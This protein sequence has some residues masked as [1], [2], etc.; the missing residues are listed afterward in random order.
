MNYTSL[1]AQVVDTLGS[2]VTTAQVDAQLAFVE[3]RF[4]RIIDSPEREKEAYLTPTADIQLPADCWRL[5]DIWVMGTASSDVPTSLVQVSAAQARALYAYETNGIEAY[6]LTGRTIDF[7]PDP[8]TSNT[9]QVR[10]RYQQTI[11]ALT[12]SNTT[13]WLLTYH[14]DIYYYSLLL[15]CEAYIVNDQRLPIWK[16][17]LDEALGELSALSAKQR[18]AQTNLAPRPMRYDG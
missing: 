9:T 11:P 14:P 8:G 16:A 13:N 7:W 6:S 10:I 1:L 2:Q 15:Q 17:A 12:S 18:Y 5:R 3:A 4:N